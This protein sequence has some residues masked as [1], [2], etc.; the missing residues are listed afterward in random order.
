M[1]EAVPVGK[2]SMIAVLGAKLDELKKIIQNEL[3]EKEYVKLQMIM[4]KVK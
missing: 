1:Q 3:D 2:G 4:Q